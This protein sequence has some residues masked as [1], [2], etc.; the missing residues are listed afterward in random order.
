MSFCSYYHFYGITFII[1]FTLLLHTRPMFAENTQYAS[2]HSNLTHEKWLSP[3]GK[4]LLY[5]KF[6]PEIK[7]GEKY[8][9]IIFLHGAGER[10]A[11]NTS[12][13][14]ND[15]FLYLLISE[16]GQKNPSFLIAPQCPVSSRW[17]DVNWS[18]KDTH[19]TPKIPSDELKM[20]HELVQNMLKNL[21]IDASRIYITGLSM[22]GYGT[23]DYVIRWPDQIAAA[24][25]VC[26]GADNAA[27]KHPDVAAVPFWFFHG[28][29]DTAVSVQRSRNAVRALKSVNAPDVRYTEI[30][31]AGHN[32][33][34]HAYTYEGVPE[35]LFT[36]KKP[37]K[38]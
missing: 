25:P 23:C 9:L 6:T 12:Q 30:P 16:S 21:P 17:C 1:T 10:G 38:K 24:I 3:S 27:L 31:G 29:A 18:I 15:Q 37:D 2:F 32:I 26:G 35:W 33:W 13:L 11:D 5:R 8:P 14:K 34:I 20:T 7:P 28:E 36:Q 4:T 22:G 19:I